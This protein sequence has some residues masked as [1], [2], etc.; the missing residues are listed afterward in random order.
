MG[1]YCKRGQR[2]TEGGLNTKEL[3]EL[4]QS[5][6]SIEQSIAN[7]KPTQGDESKTLNIEKQLSLV[8]SKVT[9]LKLSMEELDHKISSLNRK[10]DTLIN[11]Q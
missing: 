11:K 9:E 5:V 6:K 3:S 8:D 7:L 10:L 1:Q 2:N 4:L